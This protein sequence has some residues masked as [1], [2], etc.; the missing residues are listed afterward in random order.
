MSKIRISKDDL[1][2]LLIQAYEAGW[3]GAKELAGSVA[4]SLYIKAEAMDLKDFKSTV[5]HS[6]VT[7]GAGIPSPFTPVSIFSNFGS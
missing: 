1:K 5:K 6:S 3:H 4:D 7:G 2:D